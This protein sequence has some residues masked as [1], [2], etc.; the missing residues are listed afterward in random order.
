MLWIVKM[1]SRHFSISLEKNF[2]DHMIGS[3]EKVSFLIL[4]FSWLFPLLKH[5][6]SM[7]SGVNCQTCLRAANNFISILKYISNFYQINIFAI[8]FH[9]VKSPSKIL[10]N[11]I[12]NWFPNSFATFP[13]RRSINLFRR[14]KIKQPFNRQK[15][16]SAT[17]HV[18]FLEE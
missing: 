5:L 2:S 18:L 16:N 11:S 15:C 8:L 10:E 14:K 6:S 4:D 3:W 13:P 9:L 17:F 12:S 1:I 7:R